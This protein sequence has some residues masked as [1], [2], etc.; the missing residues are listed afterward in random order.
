MTTLTKK[1]IE[2]NLREIVRM[3]DKKTYK[4]DGEDHILRLCHTDSD[5]MELFKNLIL[6]PSSSWLFRQEVINSLKEENN[7]M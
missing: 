7:E 5:Y 3:D 1:D 6:H 4:S 2:N